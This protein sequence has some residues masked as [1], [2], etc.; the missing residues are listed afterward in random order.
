MVKRSIYYW[1]QLYSEQSVAGMSY[2]ELTPTIAV[3]I[4]NFNLFP[5]TN[6]FH[7]MYH[8]YEDEEKF[9]LD[10]VMEFHFIEIPKLLQHWKEDQLDPWSDVL[11]RWLLLLGIVDGRKDKV[12]EDIYNELE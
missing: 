10:N 1:S 8:L 9:R 4:L 7:T 12:Y 3:N 2:S 11:A 5:N 6:L